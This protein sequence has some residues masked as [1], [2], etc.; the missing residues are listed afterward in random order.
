MTAV[1]VPLDPPVARRPLS[2]EQASWYARILAEVTRDRLREIVVE[3]TSIPSQTGAE[4]PLAEHV[5]G[6]HAHAQQRRFDYA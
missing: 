3:M 5:V 1:G 6:R 2:P 4:R